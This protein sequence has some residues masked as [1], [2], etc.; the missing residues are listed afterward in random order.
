MLQLNLWG[1]SQ[2]IRFQKYVNSIGRSYS[3][4]LG[5]VTA[6]SGINVS[7]L[8]AMIK[9]NRPHLQPESITLIFIGTNDV[10]DRNRDFLQIKKDFLALVAYVRRNAPNHTFFLTTLP[11]FPRYQNNRIVMEKVKKFNQL[12][13]S[14]QEASIKHVE[15]NLGKDASLYFQSNYNNN[16]CRVDNIHLNDLGF[17]VLLREILRIGRTPR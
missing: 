17:E 8:K 1:D 11:S 12:V 9:S 6:K 2:C 14:I 13:F 16:P 5:T 7:Q 3:V 10:K 15:W 4:R